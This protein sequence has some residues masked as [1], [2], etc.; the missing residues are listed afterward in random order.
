MQAR[1]STSQESLQDV[2]RRLTEPTAHTRPM[3]ARQRAAGHDASTVLAGQSHLAHGPRPWLAATA[4]LLLWGGGQWINRQRALA[5]LFLSLQG[6]AVAWAWCLRESWDAW[7]RFA[8]LFFVEELTLR[9]AVATT[10]LLVPLIGIVGVV[11]AYLH[12]ERQPGARPAP[13]VPVL[14]AVASALVPGW[15]QILNGQL[16][17][18]V[19]FLSGWG[20]ALYVVAVA[21]IQPELWTRIDPTG[22]PLAG[23]QLSLGASVAV[24]A[25]LLTWVLAV[26][27]GWL[28]SL[29]RRRATE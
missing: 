2:L 8:H 23:V 11:Q 26:Y 17:K 12:A 16:G 14:P 7:V 5:V 27:D 25:G 20:F 28:T 15:G 21:R 1:E 6:L 22:S 9:T 10:G 29:A 18:A 24:A 19:G 13:R 4:S 3:V